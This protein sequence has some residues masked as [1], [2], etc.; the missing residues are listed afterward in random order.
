MLDA[1]AD[2]ARVRRA[3]ALVDSRGLV[4]AGRGDLGPE[5]ADLARPTELVEGDGFPPDAPI[6]L[7]ATVRALRPTILIGTTGIAG[8][9]TEA[10]VRAMAE[11]V[12]RPIVLP[13]SNPTAVSE[14]TPAEVVRWSRGR[15]LVAT[16]SPFPGIDVE[17]T[18]YEIGQANNVFAFPGIGLG[19]IVAQARQLP[20]SAF[21]AAGRA[22]ARQVTPGRLAAGALYPPVSDLRAVSRA[23]ALAVAE[24]VVA[25]GLAG[26][27][28]ETDL[29]AAVDAATWWPAYVPYIAT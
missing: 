1:G 18:R 17:G 12:P 5:K 27:P 25:G 3:I 9:F 14:A 7:L 16:G 11:A 23:I 2:E 21:L 28:A 19:A 13:L 6:D 15:A 10:V 4:H 24:D 26:I 8:S 22:L 20:E 29:E